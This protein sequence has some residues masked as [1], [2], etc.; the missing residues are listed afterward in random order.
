M[1]ESDETWNSAVDI[2]REQ[3]CESKSLQSSQT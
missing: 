2:I 1:L 3:G